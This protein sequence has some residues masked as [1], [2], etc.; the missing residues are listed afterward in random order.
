MK[1]RSP[2]GPDGDPDRDSDGDPESGG[3]ETVPAIKA[4]IASAVRRGTCVDLRGRRSAPTQVSG[5]I[6][7]ERT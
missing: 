2:I 6:Y 4:S 1:K 7:D 5:E 3:I